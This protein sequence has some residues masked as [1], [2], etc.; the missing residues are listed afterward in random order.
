MEAQEKF[1]RKICQGLSLVVLLF[2]G[3][4]PA[5]AQSIYEFDATKSRL[6]MD[7]YKEG[8]FQA[9]GHDHLMAARDF[10][11]RVLF[12]ADKIG[13]SSV[14]LR[15]A[16]RSI[17]VADPGESEKDRGTV[18]ATMLGNKVL[19]A[20]RFPEIVFTSTGVTKVETQAEGSSI[21]LAGILQLHGIEKSMS[22]PAMVRVS[23]DELIAKGEVFLRQ[24]DYGITPVKIGGG[25]VKVKDRLR[26]R[27]EIHARIRPGL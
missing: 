14:T 2:A 6:E 13:N 19:D 5:H 20:A 3:G 26:I 4:V 22:L 1:M 15:V 18:Q 25:A 11:G 23:G 9:F 17:M 21:T 10:S 16:A 7:V 8:F 27:F 24:T 12:D